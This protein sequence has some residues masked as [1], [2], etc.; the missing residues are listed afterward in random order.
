MN[1]FL[2][3]PRFSFISCHEDYS[4]ELPVT[5]MLRV[6]YKSDNSYYYPPPFNPFLSHKPLKFS[7]LF[8]MHVYCFSSVRVCQFL[9][10]FPQQNVN[11]KRN[12]HSINE[13]RKPRRRKNMR[14]AVC[15]SGHPKDCRRE[16]HNWKRN[17]RVIPLRLTSTKGSVTLLP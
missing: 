10:P 13:F 14:E 1:I 11:F 7:F 8:V 5:K 15:K 9:I 12:K 17:E 3:V 2:R 16:L 4:T 6:P